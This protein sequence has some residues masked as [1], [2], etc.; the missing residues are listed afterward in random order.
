M[1]ADVKVLFDEDVERLANMGELIEIMKGALRYQADEK[2]IS[3][4]RH[5]VKFPNGE[6]IFTIGATPEFGGFRV[7]N[8]FG[9]IRHTGEFIPVDNANAAPEHR[10][11]VVVHDIESNQ[12]LGVI[13]GNHLSAY[14]SGSISGAALDLMAPRDVKTLA[15]LGTGHHATTQLR[16]AVTVRKFQEIRV[17]SRGADNRKRFVE[18]MSKRV[19]QAITDCASAEEA[20]RNADVVL[21]A[22]NSPTPIYDAN[23]IAPTA[24]VCSVGPKSNTASELPAAIAARAAVICTDAPRQFAAF[25]DGHFLTGTQDFDRVRPVNEWLDPSMASKSADGIRLFLM[26]GLAGTEVL[27]GACLLRSAARVS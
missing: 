18:T 7:Y 6:L 19:G 25:S 10:Q 1:T 24:Y 23:W 5:Y 20:V 2:L 4:A 8:T 11:V 27:T 16:G 3:P 15:I 14:R 17:Y 22:S 9:R 26:E 21:S 12:L 13:I